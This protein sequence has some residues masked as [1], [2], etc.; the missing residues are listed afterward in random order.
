MGLYNIKA[1]YEYEGEIEADTP[2]EAEATFLE[3]L[4]MYYMGTYSYEVEEMEEENEDE[5]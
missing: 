2:E 3:D 5:D 4:N 1:M